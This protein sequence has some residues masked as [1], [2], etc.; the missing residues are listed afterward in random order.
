[1]VRLLPVLLGRLCWPGAWGRL[2]PHRES[3]ADA[4]DLQLGVRLTVTVLA[5]RVLAPAE[6]EDHELGPAIL[7][8]DLGRDRRAAHQR[9]PDLGRVAAEEEHLA[10][11]HFVP[12]AAGELLH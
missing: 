1:M 7:R 4:G 5:A 6:L 3:A 8:G 10:E 9:A 11:R 12:C 2:R